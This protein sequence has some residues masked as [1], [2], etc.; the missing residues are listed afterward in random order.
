MKM[1]QVYKDFKSMYPDYKKAVKE[2]YCKVQL[3]F[4]M[5]IDGLNKDG[6]ITDKQYNNA[7]MPMQ[8]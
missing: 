5:Y 4:S 1:S 3:E 6:V 2:D 7:L 8:R